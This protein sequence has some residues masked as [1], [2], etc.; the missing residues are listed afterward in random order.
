MTLPDFE[1][2]SRSQDPPDFHLKRMQLLM[3]SCP[4]AEIVSDYSALAS[5]MR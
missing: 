3:E 4:S 1:R 2:K 5:L